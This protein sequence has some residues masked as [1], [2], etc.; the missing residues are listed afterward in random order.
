M[1]RP[2]LAPGLRRRACQLHSPHPQVG[3][4]RLQTQRCRRT[5]SAGNRARV[6]QPAQSPGPSQSRRRRLPPPRPRRPHLKEE[7]QNNNCHPERSHD[8]RSEVMAQSKDPYRSQNATST[9]GKSLDGPISRVPQFSRVFWGAWELASTLRVPKLG[10]GIATMVGLAACV[11]VTRKQ[12]AYWK[13]S[14]TLFQQ[15][16]TADRK[17]TRPE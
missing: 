4:A 13:T 3:A 12:I 9:N 15:M 5:F 10:M 8:E 16:I 7:S 2:P 11:V 14:E 17:S 1:F 6:P